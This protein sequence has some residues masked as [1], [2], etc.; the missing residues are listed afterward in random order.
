MNNDRYKNENIIYAKHDVAPHPNH[1]QT[2]QDGLCIR[3]QRKSLI[4][5]NDLN[6]YQLNLNNAKLNIQQHWD[7]SNYSTK[8]QHLRWMTQNDRREERS[9]SI[10]P[11]LFPINDHDYSVAIIQN[12][13]K[14]YSDDGGFEDVADFVQLKVR[15]RISRFLQI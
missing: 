2:K 14:T 12:W 1:V 5:L 9:L 4:G 10:F 8:T 11:K 7:F 3:L 15:G 6:L 13:S